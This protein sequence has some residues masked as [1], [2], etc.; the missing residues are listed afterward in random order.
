ML[1]LPQNPKWDIA[2]VSHSTLVNADCFDIFPFIEDKSIDAI[3]CDLPYG[4]LNRS[5]VISWDNV[6]DLDLLWK[7]Y[8]RVIKTIGVIILTAS[9][10]FASRL[11]LSNEKLFKQELIWLKKDSADFV[12]AKNRHLKAHENI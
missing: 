10:P 9:Q 8:E 6:I 12:N 11:I 1:N 5:N 3:I 4:Y 7:Q 2:R